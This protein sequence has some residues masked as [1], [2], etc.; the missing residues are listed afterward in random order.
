MK[1]IIEKEQLSRMLKH[2]KGRDDR[3]RLWACAARVF[4]E[5][6]GVIAGTE[7]LVLE[8]GAC[9]MPWKAL[10]KLVQAYGSKGNVT[11]EADATGLR[12]GNTTLGHL[13]YTATAV[14]P[15]K[16]D[17]FAVTGTWIGDAAVRAM[18]ESTG[19][20]GK[21]VP[22][23]PPKPA[24]PAASVPPLPSKPP[25]PPLAKP[26]A[27]PVIPPVLKP[28]VGAASTPPPVSVSG[29]AADIRFSCPKCG[30]HFEAE[31]GMAGKETKC[32]TCGQRIIVPRTGSTAAAVAMQAP[33]DDGEAVKWLRKAADHGNATAQWYLGTRYDTGRG[34]A[35]DWTEA[36]KWFRKAAEQGH[37]EAQKTL[38]LCYAAG[39]GVVQDLVEAVKWFRKAAEQGHAEAQN[40]L[41][42]YYAAGRGVAQDCAEAV[43]WFRKAAEQGNARAQKTLGL[44]YAAGAGVVQDLVE[45]VKWFRKAAEQNYSEAQLELAECY[46]KGQGVPQDSVT[47]AA[48]R[49][50]AAAQGK[51]PA[52]PPPLTK[53]ASVPPV[54]KP[55]VGAGSNAIPQKK[56]P[57][58]SGAMVAQKVNDKEEI[59][60]AN[61]N[62]ESTDFLSLP[63]KLVWLIGVVLC[64]LVA[65]FPPWV[66]TKQGAWQQSAKHV[67]TTAFILTPPADG[68]IAGGLLTLKLLVIASVFAILAWFLRKKE[69]AL[70]WLTLK[71]GVL[72]FIVSVIC[73][74]VFIGMTFLMLRQKQQPITRRFYYFYSQRDARWYYCESFGREMT[75]AELSAQLRG[76]EL[77]V[78]E[79]QKPVSVFDPVVAEL[80]TNRSARDALIAQQLR[81]K[82][83]PW[84]QRTPSR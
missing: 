5:S 78:S 58:G 55:G 40:E 79:V 61:A 28:A 76:H 74:S 4:V 14:P 16:F 17:V 8:D 45:A 25:A 38:G 43:K 18:Q 1:F 44:C 47:A 41:G 53:P 21:A 31:R 42:R 50:K 54:V 6:N 23:S 35:Q 30:Q 36:V 13:G 33:Q 37:A 2:T 56:K 72:L 67:Y 65:V 82:V 7:S 68:Q 57:S 63:Q 77:P 81:Y 70:R 83:E 52:D 19:A 71:V 20:A 59:M 84:S 24:P 60:N 22:P 75:S 27:P 51:T 3:L 10:R 26:T 49:A 69:W 80:A 12:F 46:A 11:V 15:A 66:V 62:K 64:L 9:I 32:P 73:G 34:V 39:A 29:E 48:W